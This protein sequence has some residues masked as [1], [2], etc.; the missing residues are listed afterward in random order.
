MRLASHLVAMAVNIR[1]RFG[2]RV[3]CRPVEWHGALITGRCRLPWLS[4]S[5]LGL[6]SVLIAWQLLA[7]ARSKGLGSADIALITRRSEADPS[8]SRFMPAS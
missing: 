7:A 1:L 4:G 3:G 6:L 8:F 5:E 2:V